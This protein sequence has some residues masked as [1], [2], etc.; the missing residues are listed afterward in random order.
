MAKTKDIKN[1]EIEAVISSFSNSGL[2]ILFSFS[3]ITVA[4][5]EDLRRKFKEKGLNFTVVKKTLLSIALGKL[6]FDEAKAKDI[7]SQLDQTSA[8]GWGGDEVSQAKVLYEFIKNNPQVSAKAGFLESSLFGSE[9]LR[10][11]S[12]IPGRQELYAQVAGIFAST[13]RGILNVLN[14]PQRQMVNLLN[15]YVNK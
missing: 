10:Q 1:K 4:Q 2:K 8:L 5:T 13:L 14:G 11:L 15:N 3:G 12:I 9:E 7:L 6:G